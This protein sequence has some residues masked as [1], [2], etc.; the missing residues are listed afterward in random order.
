MKAPAMAYTQADL[1]AIDAA[2]LNIGKSGV[3]EVTF[4]DGK[5]VRYFDLKP[6]LEVRKLAS[7]SIAEAEGRP[8]VRRV[9]VYADKGL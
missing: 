3:A 7:T 9:R 6:L 5:K 2:I 4:A 8:R 1:D